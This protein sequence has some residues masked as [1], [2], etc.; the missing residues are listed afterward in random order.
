MENMNRI[1]VV[2][3]GICIFDGGLCHPSREPSEEVIISQFVAQLFLE[4][5]LLSTKNTFFIL[6]AT[7]HKWMLAV[8]KM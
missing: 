8:E 1:S 7:I 5:F 4:V 6:A 2:L 3:L